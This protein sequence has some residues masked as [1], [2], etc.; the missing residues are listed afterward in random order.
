MR[1][2]QSKLFEG[3]TDHLA[4][5]CLASSQPIVELWLLVRIVETYARI[6]PSQ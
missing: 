1:G 3:Q 6:K 2:H 4:V 5:D